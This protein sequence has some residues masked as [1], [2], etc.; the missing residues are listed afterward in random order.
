M[1]IKEG[2]KM[3]MLVKPFKKAKA[4]VEKLKSFLSST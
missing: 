2:R 1:N 4:D 3:K